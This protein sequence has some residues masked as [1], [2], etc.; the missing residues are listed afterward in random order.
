MRGAC[1]SLP[2]LGFQEYW[3]S[4]P[5]RHDRDC[6][7][8]A[9]GPLKAPGTT[10][11]PH[12]WKANGPLKA[13]GTT[14]SPHLWIPSPLCH[15]ACCI[16]ASRAQKRSRR[17]LAMNSAQLSGPAS[18]IHPS[19]RLSATP[20]FSRKSPNLCPRPLRER[21]GINR[22]SPRRAQTF[23]R[24][25]QSAEEPRMVR[26][27]GSIYRYAMRVNMRRGNLCIHP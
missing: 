5:T 17:R 25:G 22:H 4:C 27:H 18:A 26:S 15:Y 11:S 1:R 13:P 14:A 20:A 19:S 16:A 6:A 8:K 21:L 23:Q 9:N 2:S 3:G 7:W 10:A 24:T 12:L